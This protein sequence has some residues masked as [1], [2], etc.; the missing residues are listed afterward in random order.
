MLSTASSIKP[1]HCEY[2]S[3][4]FSHGSSSFV[5]FCVFLKYFFAKICISLKFV[6]AVLFLI[7]PRTNSIEFKS[8]MFGEKCSATCP[9]SLIISSLSAVVTPLFLAENQMTMQT[10]VFQAQNKCSCFCYEE[11]CFFWHCVIKV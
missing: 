10:L 6:D 8:V 11:V 1:P 2:S 3:R 9:F 7:F 4:Y 5:F